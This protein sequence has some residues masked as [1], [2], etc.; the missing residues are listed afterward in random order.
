[1]IKDNRFQLLD[2]YGNKLDNGEFYKTFDDINAEVG[3][4]PESRETTFSNFEMNSRC[5]GGSVN[6]CF[7]NAVNACNADI[8]CSIECHQLVGTL[9][10]HAAIL[11]ACAIHCA[12]D[13]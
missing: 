2:I 6:G 13:E 3:F 11:I 8:W 12:G 1:M 10:C 9:R 5:L 7:T 4:I